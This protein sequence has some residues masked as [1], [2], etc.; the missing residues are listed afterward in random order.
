MRESS[1][2]RAALAALNA[3]PGIW[4]I[5]V[6]GNPYQAAGAPDICVVKDGLSLW[7]EM[8]KPG[9]GPTPLQKRIAGRIRAAGGQVITATSVKEAMDFVLQ[10][11]RL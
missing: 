9:E 5:K 3:L 7:I 10:A 1:L 4:A 11:R 2:T 6:H 8:K